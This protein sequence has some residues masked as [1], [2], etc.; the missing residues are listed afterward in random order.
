MGTI[1][2]VIDWWIDWLEWRIRNKYFTCIN[3]TTIQFGRLGGFFPKVK[4]SRFE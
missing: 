4:N 1:S 2:E 3:K